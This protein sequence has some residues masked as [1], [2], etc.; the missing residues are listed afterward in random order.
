[1]L[2]VIVKVFFKILY[3]K[4]KAKIIAPCDD[5]SVNANNIPLFINKRSAAV[6]R[7]YRRIDLYVIYS[8]LKYS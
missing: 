1:M 7:I 5:E 6:T 4:R 8:A 2:A 3:R